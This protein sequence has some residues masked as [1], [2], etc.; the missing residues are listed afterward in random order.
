MI[1][2]VD[3]SARGAA[4]FD[5]GRSAELSYEELGARVSMN[6]ALLR[7]LPRPA[8]AF[9]F[10]V[11]SAACVASYLACLAEGVPLGLGEP[12]ETS[13][14]RVIE[15][16]R[17]SALI[18][19]RTE[20]IPGGYTTLGELAGSELVLCQAE[21][22]AYPVAPHPNLALLL[23]TSGSTGDSKFVRLSL[24]NLEA[25][26]RSIS[27]YLGLGPGEV[28]AQSLPMHYSYGLS[29]LNS[30]LASGGA[31]A[32]IGHSFMRPEF[33]GVAGECGCTS[34]AG[35]PYMYETLE[36]L[37]FSPFATPSV[38]TLTQAGGHLKVEVAGRVLEAARAQGG[39]LFVMYG[40]TEATARISYVPPD[41]LSQ[42]MGSIGLAIP[43]GELWLEPVDSDPSRNQ[44]HYRGRN[45]MLGYATGPADLGRGDEQGGVLATGD[46]AEMDRDGFYRISGRLARF[47]KLFGKRINLAGI[48][49]DLEQRFPVRAAALQGEDCLRIVLEGAVT[50]DA[51]SVRSH[52]TGVLG[53]PPAA[54]RVELAGRLPMTSSGKKDY[55]ALA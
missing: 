4:L 13:R 49:T 27:Q 55:R 31:L 42:K 48:E 40:Q 28:A 9:Q 32:L 26:A 20:R 43:G 11:N 12:A 5:G 16:Y 25:N 30:H 7:Q 50:S 29:V 34:F 8:V 17:P 37:R 47:A 6:R 51:V 22:G 19:A 45:V 46:L 10:A 24:E 21:G 53:V 15:A 38:R 1:S 23:A 54:V 2:L 44:L 14:T 41:R 33:W 36:R 18:L 3:F 52:L 39:R 35:V